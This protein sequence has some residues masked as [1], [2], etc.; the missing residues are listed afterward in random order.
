MT[1]A[2][3]IATPDSDLAPVTQDAVVGI[4]CAKLPARNF[5]QEKRRADITEWLFCIAAR[6]RG[7]RA[8]HFGS[9][10]KGY[11]V[12]L[13]RD[14]MR[15]IF[16]QVK[17]GVLHRVSDNQLT[18]AYQ[19][20]NCSRGKIYDHAAYDILA[21]YM[22]DREEWLL[23]QRNEFGNQSSARYLPP[24]WRR[25]PRKSAAHLD[26]R[27]PDNWELLDQVAATHSQE[28]SRGAPTDV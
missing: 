18:G 4:P 28:S 19:I 16:V 2:L 22:W 20:W 15:P 23:F 14:G 6:E 25:T 17:Y 27:N 9:Q 10:C 11:D 24:E 1:Q 8:K 26:D 12:I 7:Y 3:L 5:E 21:F 13:E